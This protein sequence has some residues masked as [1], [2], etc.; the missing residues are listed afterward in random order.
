M[1]YAI[2]HVH[3]RAK[4]PKVSAAWYEKIFNAKIISEREVMPGTITIGL[5]V[6]GPTR[7]NISS[8]PPNSSP[9]KAVPELNRL[10]LEHFGFHVEDLESEMDRF[11]A[12]GI[13][14]ILPLTVTPQGIRLAYIEGPAD[15]VSEL[16]Q[17]AP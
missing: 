3:I 13:R 1:D 14:V 6:G 4:E 7:L 12:E 8:Q 16:D 2:N 11:E 5:Q 9:E 17:A 15:V 10:G